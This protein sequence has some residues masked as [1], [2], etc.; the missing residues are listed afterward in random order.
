MEK[1]TNV[2][3]WMEDPSIFMICSNPNYK[4]LKK[5]FKFLKDSEYVGHYASLETFMFKD[6]QDLILK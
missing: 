5:R 2:Y 1:V 3:F 4:E 6:K